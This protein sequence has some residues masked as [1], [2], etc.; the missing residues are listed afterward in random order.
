MKSTTWD[1]RTRS[2]KIDLNLLRSLIYPNKGAI[3]AELN[4]SKDA[5]RP[6]AFRVRTHPFRRL[7]SECIMGEK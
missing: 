2:I 4:L 5:V 1:T 7:V 6:P 3:R